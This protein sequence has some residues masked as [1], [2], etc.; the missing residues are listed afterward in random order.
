MTEETD[1]DDEALTHSLTDRGAVHARP[2]R[3]GVLDDGG[4]ALLLVSSGLA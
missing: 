3:G 1:A 4:D 2:A